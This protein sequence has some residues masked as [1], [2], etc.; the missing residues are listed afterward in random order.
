MYRIMMKSYY[1]LLT[2]ISDISVT[3]FDSSNSSVSGN[4]WYLDLNGPTPDNI[5]CGTVDKNIWYNGNRI[6][7]G[8]AVNSKI[9]YPWQISLR[10]KN[11]FSGIIYHICGGTIISKDKVITAAHCTFGTFPDQLSLAAGVL[12]IYNEPNGESVHNIKEIINHNEFN[13]YNIQA[14]HDIS[15]LVLAEGSSFTWSAAIRPVCLPNFKADLVR[16]TK[17]VTT[18]WG[19]IN[20][21][22][23]KAA[24]TLMEIEVRILE[25]NSCEDSNNFV[26]CAKGLS[27]DADPTCSGDSGGPLVCQRVFDARWELTGI[28]SYGYGKEVEERMLWTDEVFVGGNKEE[29]ESAS[30]DMLEEVIGDLQNV[31]KSEFGQPGDT[32][33]FW[34]GST[35]H[36]RQK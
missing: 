35:R 21:N 25:D 18:G 1:L 5:P 17:C 19:M 26:L 8:T 3:A 29:L 6:L 14:G 31:Y 27:T 23:D 36:F 16:Y 2:Y 15:I 28:T 4:L 12:D 24:K 13:L 10:R 32:I 22:A 30:A 9:T 7:S 11:N 33:R 20:D 34:V